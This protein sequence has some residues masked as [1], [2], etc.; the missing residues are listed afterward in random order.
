MEELLKHLND[1]QRQAVEETEGPVLVLAGAG[2][3]KTRVLTYRIAK[4]IKDGVRP[5]NILAVTFTNKA[6]GEIKERL[7]RLCGEKV[8]T[9]WAGTFHSVC[10]RMLREYGEEIGISKKFTIYDEYAQKQCVKQ[11]VENLKYDGQKFNPAKIINLIS[12]A[13]EK[14]VTPENYALVFTDRQAVQVGKI[15]G[16]YMRL[17]RENQALD[18][19]DL[20]NCGVELLQKSEKVRRHYQEKFRY[21]HVDEFQDIN[22]SQYQLVS[23]LARPNNNI[24]CVGDDDQS[25][26]GWRGADI[27]IILE[28]KNEFRGCKVFKL[29]Q[30]YRSTKNILA[31]AYEVVKKN[32]KRNEKT[33]WTDNEQG[34]TIEVFEGSDSNDEA[35]LVA[36]SIEKKVEE[37]EFS[38]SDIAILYRTN[39]LSR[40]FEN[41]FNSY[42]KIPYDIYGGLRFFDRKEVK[43]MLSYLNVI[44]N[45]AD[46]FSLRRIINTPAR[47]IGD[48][49]LE[50]LVIFAEQEGISLFK[51]LERNEEAGV[52]TAARNSI[53][54]FV[55]LIKHFRKEAVIFPVDQV[56]KS[57]LDFSGY[58]DMLLE[59]KNFENEEKLSNIQELINVA[60]NFTETAENPTLDEFLQNVSLQSDTDNMTEDGGRVLLMTVHAAK[61]LEFPVVYVVGLEEGTFPHERSMGNPSEAE[62]ERRL[63][64]VAMTRAKKQLILTFSDLRQT[65][66]N[67]DRKLPSSFLGDIPKVYFTDKREEEP[68]EKTLSEVLSRT[69]AVK[70][71]G[72]T[73][74]PGNRLKHPSY[75]S[76]I[77][78]NCRGEG[79]SEI[80][81]VI[82][83]DKRYGMKKFRVSKSS[84]E[85]M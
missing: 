20:I 76:C 23:L 49:T 66:G 1:F 15:Y 60:S 51:A 65:N 5:S 78:L 81:T 2:S 33:I 79:D 18:F 12:N 30:N 75:G 43:D 41:Y 73:Y 39:S 54:S 16:E 24:F 7:R 72:Q 50:K 40:N 71:K 61:G 70:P 82:F 84:F 6:A 14:L 45:E 28:F 25:I 83:D 21:V 74:T 3:G 67:W 13:K 85:R 55:K 47:G 48:A 19:D 38:Y 63:M 36:D 64:Y 27:S 32:T 77:V 68:E 52:R 80:V 57:V 9:I 62:E 44:N 31:A 53:N 8:K 35:R 59:D 22:Y 10:V 17:C 56:I 42:T 46:N 11:A 69:E 26:Y 29:E 37:G 58:K 34:E 4:I